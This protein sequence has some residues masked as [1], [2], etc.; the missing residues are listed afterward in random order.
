MLKPTAN[1]KMS[2]PLKTSLALSKMQDPHL[3]GQW[4]RAM[5]QAELYAAI[6][7]KKEKR[8]YR[9]TNTPLTDVVAGTE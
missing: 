2:K 8:E 1:Y 4:K 9:G 6:A 5:I 3:K 7:P